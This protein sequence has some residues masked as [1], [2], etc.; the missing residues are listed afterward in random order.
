MNVTL[1]L[2]AAAL[3]DRPP[4]APSDEPMVDA[5]PY[6]EDERRWCAWMAQAQRGDAAAYARL[7][8]EL[9]MTVE[10]Y[11]R[12]RFGPLDLLE[13]CVQ[14]CLMTLHQARHTYDPT[15]QFRPWLFTLVRHKTIDVLRRRPVWCAVSPLDRPDNEAASPDRQQQII[16]GIR[17]LE[18]LPPEYREAV[19]L[20]K[21]GGYTTAEAAVH[22]GI[23]ES[24]LKARLQRG[25]VAIRRLLD[26]EEVAP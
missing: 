1:P 26:D 24:A 21:Y 4:H 14:E 22:A 8:A 9:G 5:D 18:R 3:A 17:I 13:D 12:A 23:S 16:D 20:A 25:L 10:A 11:I 15:Q 7:L 6:A 2:A 19:T